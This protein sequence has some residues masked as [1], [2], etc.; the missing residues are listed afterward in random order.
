MKKAFLVS[1]VGL[2]AGGSIEVISS[3][4]SN[5][6][7]GKVV[8]NIKGSWSQ[9]LKFLGK[10][11]TLDAAY[12]RNSKEGFLSE[13]SLSGKCDDVSYSVKTTFEGD[14]ELTLAADTKDGTSVEAVANNKDGITKV[15]AARG[16]TFQGR[17][18]DVEASHAPHSGES[19]LKLSSVL[20]H[21]VKAIATLTGASGAKGD[22]N[23]NQ[24]YEL[25]Y[26]GSIGEGRTVSANVNPADGTGE[27]ELVDSKTIDATVTATLPLGGKP[28]LTVKRS[29]GF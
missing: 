12:D 6:G 16:T 23:T 21:G 5:R 10:E 4:L 19:K 3:D 2:A 24:A 25:E 29:W 9:T 11:A 20:G 14:T 28:K 18:V 15:T 17:D 1:T 13:A 8:D 26:E 27:V 7:S 22:Y